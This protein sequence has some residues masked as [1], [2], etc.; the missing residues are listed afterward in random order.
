MNTFHLNTD[1]KSN[2]YHKMLGITHQRDKVI[3]A[4]IM[5]TV[6]LRFRF[7]T[8]GNISPFMVEGRIST[9]IVARVAQN[10]LFLREHILKTVLP[11]ID[12]DS[13][14]ELICFGINIEDMVNTSE[15][16]TAEFDSMLTGLHHDFY[17]ENELEVI[18]GKILI[19]NKALEN[20]K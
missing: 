9:E 16:D 13:I 7:N 1:N 6:Y 8:N 20:N 12:C 17:D 2:C 15:E 14:A 18:T 19:K 4:L 5:A 11:H 3:R 10:S